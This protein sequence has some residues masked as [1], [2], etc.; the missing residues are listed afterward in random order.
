MKLVVYKFALTAYPVLH[1]FYKNQG[2][3]ISMINGQY[4]WNTAGYNTNIEN[5]KF[6]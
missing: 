1:I 2:S 3:I 6:L 4:Y 5:K